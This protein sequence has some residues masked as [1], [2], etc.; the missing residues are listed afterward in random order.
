M[1]FGIFHEFWS[2]RAGSQA[3]AFANSFAQIQAAEEWGLDAVWLAE[4]HMNPTRA[5]VPAPLV[6]ASAIAARTSRIKIGTAVHILPPGHPRPGREPGARAAPRGRPRPDPPARI[7]SAGPRAPALA[8][9]AAGRTR[10]APSPAD[11][12]R[13]PPVYAEVQREKCIVGTPDMVADRLR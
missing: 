7:H 5:L 11:R 1:E 4:I 13:G 12:L 3:E 2:T 8:E 10:S 9:P 6:I